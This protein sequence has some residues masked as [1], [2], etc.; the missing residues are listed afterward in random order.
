MQVG[1]KQDVSRPGR[2]AEKATY[3]IIRFEADSL[4]SAKS[5]RHSEDEK[6]IHGW[7]GIS[8]TELDGN[9]TRTA[10]LGENGLHR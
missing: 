1:A 5:T 7:N 3:D 9:R 6:G 2:S 10:A 8:E 4:T